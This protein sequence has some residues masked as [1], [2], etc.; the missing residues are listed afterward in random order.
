VATTKLA[1][2]EAYGKKDIEKAYEKLAD[3]IEDVKV[4]I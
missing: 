1:E 3:K 4:N 2:V